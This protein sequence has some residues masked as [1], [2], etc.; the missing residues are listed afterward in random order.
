MF[1]RNCV[2]AQGKKKSDQQQNLQ[3]LNP[4]RHSPNPDGFSM[5]LFNREPIC[6][7]LLYFMHLVMLCQP[8][9]QTET[10]ILTRARQQ[11]LS[12]SS[13]VWCTLPGRNRTPRF[14]LHWDWEQQRKPS[15]QVKADSVNSD[16]GSFLWVIKSCCQCCETRE[17]AQ[18][19]NAARSWPG[20]T[21]HGKSMDFQ[22]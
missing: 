20:L 7:S 13:A 1:F 19:L 5:E 2:P 15:L 11:P 17:P 6:R 22:I 3:A 12:H 9:P 21:W 8:T 14:P 4:T 10:F 18:L 16:T